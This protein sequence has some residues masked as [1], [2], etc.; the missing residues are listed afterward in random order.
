LALAGYGLIASAHYAHTLTHPGCF[1]TGLTPT[2]AGIGNAQ[3]IAYPAADELTLQAWYV[4]PQ[5]GAVVILLPGLQGGRD[6][7]LREAAVLAGHGYGLLAT[8]LRSCAHPRGR[9][10]LGHREAADLRAAVDWLA[11]QRGVE[12]VAV[13]GYSL[14]GVA[15][16]LG[17]AQDP[18]IEAVVAEGNF[19]DLVADVTNAGRADPLWN[20]LIY[21]AVL[22]FLRR[23][24]RVPP[25]EISPIASIATIS[26]RPVLLVYGDKEAEN[27]HAHK[28]YARAQEPKALWIV[29]N[30]GHGQY[31]DVAA[32]EWEQRVLGFLDE[33]VGP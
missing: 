16:I 20:R 3:D 2:D 25:Q 8:E 1:E 15:A 22:T 11:V 4:P 26:P 5:N 14:G 10:T 28:L 23:E 18:R 27:A 9:T 33:A 7:L 17:S 12:R 31:L 19:H 21:R 32:A 24:L 6:G 30:C 13:L 29:P